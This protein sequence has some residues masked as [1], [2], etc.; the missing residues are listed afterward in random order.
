MFAHPDDESYGPG[1]TIAHYAIEG[2]HVFILMFTCGEAGSIGISKELPADE[3]CRRRTEEFE[4][5]C[6]ALGVT[7]FRLLGVP[8]KGVADVDREWAIEQILAA[9]REYRPQVALT[10]HRL[11]VSGHPD[12]VAVAGLLRDAFD[13]AGQVGV[14]PLKLY[15]WGIPEEKGRLYDRPN[16]RVTPAGELNACITPGEN[17]MDRKI[18]AIRRHATQIEFFNSLQDQFDY[19]TV[20]SPEWF[21]R[22]RSRVPVAGCVETDLF[23]GVDGFVGPARGDGAQ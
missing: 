22:R 16:L 8:D 2:V 21:T 18:A 17:A 15:E 20:A 4:G 14:G 11:G 5:A 13:R 9:F 12:H 10:F 7:A 1:G 6:K 23:A 3:L 19:R